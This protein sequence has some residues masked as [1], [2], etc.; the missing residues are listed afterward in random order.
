MIRDALNRLLWVQNL[1]YLLGGIALVVATI[2]GLAVL[3]VFG[4]FL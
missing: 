1:P 4:V 2:V 3:F